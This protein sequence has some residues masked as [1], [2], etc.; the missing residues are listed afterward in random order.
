[1]KINKFSWLII[2]ITTLTQAGF[3]DEGIDQNAFNQ[4]SAKNIIIALANSANNANINLPV[5]NA[6][7]TGKTNFENLSNVEIDQ[8]NHEIEFM[9]VRLSFDRG[10]II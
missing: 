10:S 3:A 9:S 4:T 8:L 7:V 1:M 2:L 5:L 6:L